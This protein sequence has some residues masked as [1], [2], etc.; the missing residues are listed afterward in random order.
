MS[1]NLVHD[2]SPQFSSLT[3]SRGAT[4]KAE[5]VNELKL[6]QNAVTVEVDDMERDNKEGRANYVQSEQSDV[7]GMMKTPDN[8]ASCSR[9]RLSRWEGESRMCTGVW[10]DLTCIGS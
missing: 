3:G 4:V 1:R 6:K 10:W 7:L 2:K 8:T 5:F 9:K